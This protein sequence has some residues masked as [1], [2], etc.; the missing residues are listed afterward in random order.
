MGIANEDLEMKEMQ[1]PGKIKYVKEDLCW[2]EGGVLAL[3]RPL[4]LSSS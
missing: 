1:R 2:R 3:D 4:S